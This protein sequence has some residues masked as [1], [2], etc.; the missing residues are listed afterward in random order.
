MQADALEALE[1]G[2]LKG[3]SEAVARLHPGD[4]DSGC[5]DSAC[6]DGKTLLLLS[7]EAQKG[8]PRFC[9]ALL[10]AGAKTGVFNDQIGAYPV[11]LAVMHDSLPHVLVSSKP[12]HFL[13]NMVS[14]GLNFP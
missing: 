3:F 6:K 10:E 1:S 9:H 2:D 5:I 4:S 11:H 12:F 13:E 7:I 8:D 14:P